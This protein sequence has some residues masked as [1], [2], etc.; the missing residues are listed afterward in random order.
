MP[1][2][3]HFSFVLFLF[4][5]VRL[6]CSAYLSK[7]NIDTFLFFSLFHSNYLSHTAAHAICRTW[8]NYIF[9]INFKLIFI[10]SSISFALNANQNVVF[11]CY[12]ESVLSLFLINV[13]NTIEI[14]GKKTQINSTSDVMR[15]K[16]NYYKNKKTNKN[17]KI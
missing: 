14:L 1:P 16:R 6:T 4:L 3:T 13:K 11:F 8:L 15:W 17:S 2:C 7:K 10:S 9:I 5:F 12:F